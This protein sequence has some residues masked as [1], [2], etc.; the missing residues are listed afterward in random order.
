MALSR[1]NYLFI[2]S[3][4]GGERAAAIYTPIQTVRFN[5]IEPEDWVATSRL[6][7]A[8]IRCQRLPLLAAAFASLRDNTPFQPKRIK[9]IRS[10]CAFTGHE[11]A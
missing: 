4:K 3:D 8:R 6:D 10:R 1:R 9:Q 2:G 11:G 5:F 7:S